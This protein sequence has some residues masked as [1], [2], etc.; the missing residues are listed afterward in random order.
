[1]I[2]YNTMH[3]LHDNKFTWCFH[4]F[5]LIFT[6]Q[7]YEERI[8]TSLL[9]SGNLLQLVIYRLI[10]TTCSKSVDN[11]F[12]QA[13]FNKSVENLQQTYGQQAVASHANTF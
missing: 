9:Q 8:A 10:E 13:N 7:T 11:K 12:C 4:Y 5:I 1:M 2:Q 6:M 3:D